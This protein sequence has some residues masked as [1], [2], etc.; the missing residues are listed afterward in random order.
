MYSQ[1]CESISLI[2]DLETGIVN[3]KERDGVNEISTDYP[4]QCKKIFLSRDWSNNQFQK[5]HAQKMS[6]NNFPRGKYKRIKILKSNSQSEMLMAG[7][8]DIRFHPRARKK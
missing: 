2:S 6:F 8:I 3:V 4:N 5:F 7:P 1:N